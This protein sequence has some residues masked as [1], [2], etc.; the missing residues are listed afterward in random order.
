MTVLVESSPQALPLGA[1]CVASALKNHN[2]IKNHLEVGLKA[3]SME[4]SPSLLAALDDLFFSY[5]KIDFLCMSVFVW[6]RDF[7]Q[8]LAMEVRKKSPGTILIAGGPEVTANPLSFVDFDYAVSGEG[9]YSLPL[10]VEKLLFAGQKFCEQ[11]SLDKD[12]LGFC[13]GIQGVYA[14]S[15]ID[16]NVEAEGTVLVRSLPPDLEKLPSPYLDA[17][18]NAADYGGALWELAR[19]CPFKCSYCYESRGEKRVRYFP[20]ERLEKEAE[21]FASQK[22]PQVFVLDPTYN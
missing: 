9:E 1:A 7:S 12:A 18:L 13:F 16:V 21:L 8:A 4:R 3:F 6:N 19:G 11:A 15:K 10:L 17:S 14:P 20:R 5:P 2:P 22:I